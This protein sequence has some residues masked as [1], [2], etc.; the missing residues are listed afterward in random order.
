MN[1]ALKDIASSRPLG[2]ARDLRGAELD[3]AIVFSQPIILTGEYATLKT[4]NGQWCF[5]DSLRLLSRIVGALTVVL[6]RGLD[7]F[8]M[9]LRRLAKSV[10]TKRSVL[11]LYEDAPV[12]WNSAAAILN[13]GARSNEQLPWTSVNSNGWVARV[14]SGPTPLS[15]DLH[16]S[17][18]IAALFAA[19]LGVTEIFKRIYGIPKDKAPLLNATQFSLFELNTLPASDGPPLPELITLPDTV[20]VGGGAI[21]NGI[22][23]LMSQLAPKGRLHLIDKQTFQRENFGTC[24]LLD[25]PSWI[26]MSKAGKLAAWLSESCGLRCTGEEKSVADA[27]SGELVSKMNVELVLNGL[28]DI[29]ARHD[30]QR[31]WPSVLV[32]GGINSVGAAV[33]TQCLSRPEGACMICTF[34]AMKVDERTLQSQI[35]GLSIASLSAGL[36]RQLTHQDILHAHA[37]QRDW[38]RSQFAQGK[39]IC[40]T[41]TEAQSRSL[42]IAT[43]SGFSPSAP[44]VATA[45]AALVVAQALK[46]LFFPNAAF[47][48][49]FQIESLFIGP[50]ASTSVLTCADPA[51]EC[52]VHR[53][54]IERIALSRRRAS[55]TQSN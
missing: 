18:P 11:I 40:S 13:I 47:A 54:L 8:E 4:Q 42:G 15:V 26:G 38:L 41:I 51:C 46:A 49:R 19:S 28:D 33:T 7:Q 29:S 12:A 9:E 24:V 53:E 43:E 21:G 39:T 22:M 17:N 14:S 34:R 32:D 48:Q 10:W 25:D 55:P 20:V 27:R 30:A 6:P 1:S 2:V 16:Q 3:E 23:L 35:T 52:V 50:E 44:F 45:S 37:S 31:L 36:D 5:L